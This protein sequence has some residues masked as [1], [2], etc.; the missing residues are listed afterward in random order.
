MELYQ[1]GNCEMSMFELWAVVAAKRDVPGQIQPPHETQ[2]VKHYLQTETHTD[3]RQ[4]QKMV[5]CEI[6]NFGWL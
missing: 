1:K 6:S 4:K 2:R 5:K 3:R